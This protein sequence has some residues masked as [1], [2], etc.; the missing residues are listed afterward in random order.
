MAV[1]M[2]FSTIEALNDGFNI[3][4]HLNNFWPI[5]VPPLPHVSFGD[6]S[7]DPP[8]PHLRGL[9]PTGYKNKENC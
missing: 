4:G 1:K 3:C 9:A 6:T 7:A 2:L 8:P 5:F